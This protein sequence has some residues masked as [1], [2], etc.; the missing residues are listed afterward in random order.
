MKTFKLLLVRGFLLV[1][2]LSLV[3]ACGKSAA[4]ADSVNLN[5]PVTLVFKSQFG[6]TQDTFDQKYGNK[7]RAKFPN[8][9]I[10]FSQRDATNNINTLVNSGDVPDIMYGN[11]SGIDDLLINPGLAYDMTPMVQKYHYDLNRF[12]PVLLD[13]IRKTNPTG[14]LYGLPMPS[15][16]VQVLFYNKDLF[17]KFGVGYPKDGMT[18]DDVY[19]LAKQL[20]RVDGGTT[21]R[22]FSSF[23]SAILRDNQ[24]SVPYLDPKADQMADP[25]KWTQ[26][27]NNLSRFYAIPNNTRD[28]KQKSQTYELQTF[29]AQKNVAMQVN[30]FGQYT[31]FPADMHWD[32]VSMPV[33]KDGP[34]AANQSQYY[35]WFITNS[36]QHKDISFQIV[37]YM[38]SDEMQLADTKQFADIPSL[39]SSS[40]IYKSIGQD[41]PVLQGKNIHATYYYAPAPSSPARDPKLIGADPNDLKVT[42]E[43][44]F[45]QVTLSNVDI[46]TAMRDAQDAMSKAIDK[47]KQAAQ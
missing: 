6:D 41:V 34:K 15:G 30:Q 25:A 26:I 1:L 22:G 7:I 42:M 39:K 28:P 16:G 44:E 21:Y 2:L 33:F 24:L 32:M 40:S 10:K 4:P 27:F 17:D 12:E 43:N 29:A 46:N 31:S 8:V 13:N 20:S 47:K 19:D 3:S 36:N 5:E 23:I 37:S 38:L 14:A 11:L 9:T 35:Y 18:W 45:N